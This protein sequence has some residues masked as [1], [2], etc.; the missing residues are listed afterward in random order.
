M[1][2]MLFA[3]VTMGEVRR[4]ITFTYAGQKA[5]KVEI[6]GDFNAWS[7]LLPMARSGAG[8][9]RTFLLPDTARIEYKLIVDGKW[10]LDP[11]NNS[12]INNGIGGENSVWK[13][14][15]YSVGVHDGPPKHP[16]QR[17]ELQVGERKVIVFTPAESA[18]LPL[19]VYGDGESYE[20]PGRV[21]NVLENLVESGK[22][23]PAVIVLVQPRDRMLEYGGGWRAY[24]QYVF[25]DVLPTVR[26]RTDASP[27]PEDTYMGGS[28]LGGLISLRL[29]EE[30]PDQLAGGIQC[31]SAAIQWNP[32]SINY[33]EAASLGRLKK[34]AP[35]CRIW[36]DWGEFEDTL[37]TAN[38]KLASTLREMHHPFGYKTT[39]E[40]HTWTAWRNRMEAGLIYLLPP[41]FKAK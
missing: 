4:P 29:A 25:L 32:L 19:V 1:L 11:A 9:S 7:K 24:G 35:S 16:L 31:Q 14:P 22:I 15:R 17:I 41:K 21:Q 6:A 28:S 3:T 8:W 18:D 40:G 23:R 30:F 20:N 36:L 13:G 34:I 12:H 10:I 38:Q 26:R 5:A 2:S 27:R 33:N 39:P 37:T